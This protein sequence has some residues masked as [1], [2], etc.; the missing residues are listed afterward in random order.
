MEI[1]KSLS[2]AKNNIT[3]FQTLKSNLEEQM[4]RSIEQLTHLK[5]SRVT[6]INEY[7]TIKKSIK[8]ISEKIIEKMRKRLF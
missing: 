5:Q 4:Q 3:R 1:W 8:K 2:E 7:K 6:I